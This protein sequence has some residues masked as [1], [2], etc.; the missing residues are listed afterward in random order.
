[1][2]HYSFV[3]LGGL[4]RS[5]TSLLHDMLRSHTCISGFENTGVPQDEGQHLQSVY[6][7][8]KVLGGPGIFGYHKNAHLTELSSLATSDNATR[9]FSE[10]AVHW[11][12]TMEYL[13]EKSPPNIIRF[14]LLQAF[15]PNSRFINIIRHPVAVVLA[16]IKWTQLSIPALLDHWLYCHNILEVDKKHLKRY[17]AVSY[18][19]LTANPARQLCGILEIL[20]LEGHSYPR[21]VYSNINEEY[22]AQWRY[23]RQQRLASIYVGQIERKYEREIS[24]FGYSFQDI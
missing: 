21:A 18:E 3:F 5:G 4:H 8:A 17:L 16:T 22:F 1:M 23:L 15:F 2:N 6:P 10:W 14:R 19:A 11:D 7:P 9:L 13:I 12:L 20:G 24:R